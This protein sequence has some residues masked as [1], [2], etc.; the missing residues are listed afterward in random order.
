[1]RMEDK[2]DLLLDKY[3]A[4]FEIKLSLTKTQA[5]HARQ[6]LSDMMDE[7]TALRGV[8]P[9]LSLRGAEGDEAISKEDK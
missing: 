6:L 9:S 5:A 4:L 2:E 1:M 7:F 3:D 8:A